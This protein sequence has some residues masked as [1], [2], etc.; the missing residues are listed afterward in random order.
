MAFDAVMTY[1][2]VKS[3]EKELP[4]AAIDKIYQIDA[5]QVLF[6]FRTR[7]GKLSLILSADPS[8]ARIAPTGQSMETPKEP[9]SFCMSLRKHLIGSRVK[10]VRQHQFDRIAQISFEGLSELGDL[11]E[12]SLYLEMMGKHS[13][14]ILT[15]EGGKVLDSL[16]HVSHLVSSVR[17][18]YPG[19]RYELP[20]HNQKI[21][22]MANPLSE[23]ELV[24]KL[25]ESGEAVEKALV[26]L[27]YGFSPQAAR[28]AL[29]L[30][31]LHSEATVPFP[32][33]MIFSSLP[34]AEQR[35][36][37]K[38]ILAFLEK[39][40][41]AGEKGGAYCLYREEKGKIRDFS[42]F[43]YES[44]KGLSCTAYPSLTKLM[45][46]YY[47]GKVAQSLL[48]G[49]TRDLRQLLKTHLERLRKKKG[50]QEAQ[51]LEAKTREEDRLFGD[52]ITANLYRLK[53]GEKTLLLEDYNRPGEMVKITLDEKL[54]LSQNAQRFYQRYNK[55][56]RAEERLVSEIAKDEEEI[57]YLES[58][59]EALSL[60]D[61]EMDLVSLR[62]ELSENGYLKKSTQKK[63]QKQRNLSPSK[64]LSFVTSEGVQGLIGKNN[65]QNDHL[66]F[67]VA[68]PEDWWFHVK[69]L[70]G[71][72]VILLV[73][74]LELGKDYT[75]KSLLE[76]AGMAACYSKARDEQRAL[77]D[78]A[79]RVHVKKPSGAKPG[80]V[81]Y[82]HQK[83]VQ[84]EVPKRPEA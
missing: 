84:V 15:G 18:V 71:S 49:R 25:S 19:V 27:F 46:A 32:E 59:Q 34:L 13:N 78:Y 43:P 83:S 1:G 52:L 21:D 17:P 77:V 29:A 61:C 55:K 5:F 82:T 2:V 44:L 39:V 31:F 36:I 73:S 12:K 79:L 30:A 57:A 37:A 68:R 35:G 60:A 56:K 23:E 70:P 6:R 53:E 33:K 48:E 22:L 58:L 69:D 9:P 40:K 24:S 63:G 51:L 47:E 64:P 75:E 16:K 14:L 74:G 45:D 11:A 7:T 26:D 50:L 20:S 42:L 62:E 54:S 76:A 66:T 81:R 10:Y 8:Y 65:V 72:H 67:H 3:L 4:G 41:T 38:G 28:E 80:F